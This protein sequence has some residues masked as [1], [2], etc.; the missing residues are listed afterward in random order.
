[1]AEPTENGKTVFAT[2]RTHPEGCIWVRDFRPGDYEDFPWVC[3]EGGI[4]VHRAKWEAFTS[5][6]G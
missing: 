1:M 3:M 2:S 6:T 5:V 4:T